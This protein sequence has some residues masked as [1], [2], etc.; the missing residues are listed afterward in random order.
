MNIPSCSDLDLDI[1][2]ET[3]SD[4]VTFCN[5]SIYIIFII[6]NAS[7]IPRQTGVGTKIME[8]FVNCIIIII[9]YSA[10]II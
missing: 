3:K 10:C 7:K 2:C 8:P 9:Y 1:H 5:T 6:L 4:I